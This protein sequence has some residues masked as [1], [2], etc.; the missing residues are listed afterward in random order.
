V[1]K[2]HWKRNRHDCHQL[3]CDSHVRTRRTQLRYCGLRRWDR[4]QRPRSSGIV[5]CVAGRYSLNNQETS[6]SQLKGWC[7]L[8]R[9]VNRPV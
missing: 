4:V 2:K 8:E 1:F 7:R 6:S 9:G 3:D 5:H